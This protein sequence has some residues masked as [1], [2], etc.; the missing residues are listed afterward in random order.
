MADWALIPMT[1]LSSRSA[2]GKMALKNEQRS[3]LLTFCVDDK[4]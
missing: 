4:K 3:F 2:L 1:L